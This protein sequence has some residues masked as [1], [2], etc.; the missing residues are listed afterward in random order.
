MI[1][2]W[3]RERTRQAF[4]SGISDA[5]SELDGNGLDGIPAAVADLRQRLTPALPAPDADTEAAPRKA[6][7]AA[8]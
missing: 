3:L 2:T 4:L 1:W 8:K 6:R 7:A 5:L